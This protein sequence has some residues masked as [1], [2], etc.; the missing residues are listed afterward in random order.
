M[1]ELKNISYAYPGQPPLL[2][3]I[4]TTFADGK[5]TSILG[6]N[7]CG[8]STLLKIICRLLPPS[9]GTILL[10]G[11]DIHTM[12]TKTYAKE[13]TLLAQTNHPPEITVEDLVAYGRYPHQKYGQGLTK[14]D[15]EIIAQSIAQVKANE[16][17]QRYVNRLS[18]GQ[19]QRA[20]IAM[21]LAQNTDIIFLDEPTT[22]L[23][24]NI[25]FEIMDLIR[26]LNQQGKTI[27]MVLHDLNLALEYSDH[28]ILMNS[29]QI[30]NQGSPQ[31]IIHSGDIDRIFDIAT[32]VFYE[33]EKQF[34]HFAKHN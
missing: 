34:Y 29:G 17:A 9:E 24:I 30:V 18:G 14:E 8:K 28:I 12:K 20:Y 31:Q 19:R 7:G 4:S 16:Y 10:H 22:Y 23:D 11:K 26:S 25:R 32:H 15:K 27:I 33:N 13:V 3:N 5:I 6:P 21:A 2:Q 1:I